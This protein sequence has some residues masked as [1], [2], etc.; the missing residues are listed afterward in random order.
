MCGKIVRIA[1]IIV[2]AGLLVWFCIVTIDTDF[3]LTMASS[4]NFIRG[5]EN[6]NEE[7]I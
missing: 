7:E 4:I 1:S 3:D 6:Q 2:N 5:F